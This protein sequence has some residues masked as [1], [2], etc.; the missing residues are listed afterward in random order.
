MVGE[1]SGERRVV[2]DVFVMTLRKGS[3]RH[4]HVVEFEEGRL[5]AWRPSEVG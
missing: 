1:Q 2:G 3:V 4:N 5:I